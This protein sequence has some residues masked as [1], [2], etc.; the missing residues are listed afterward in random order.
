MRWTCF[1]FGYVLSRP[2]VVLNTFQFS[3]WLD[4]RNSPFLPHKHTQTHKNT[5]NSLVLTLQTP[6]KNLLCTCTY[7]KLDVK[8][9]WT[10]FTWL[11]CLIR[12]NS[13]FK[14]GSGTRSCVH[15]ET[16]FVYYCCFVLMRWRQKSRIWI[17]IDLSPNSNFHGKNHGSCGHAP[18]LHWLFVE[19]FRIHH[20]WCL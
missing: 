1:L 3:D 19:N 9:F 2:F 14:P 20:K 11:Y 16:I 5:F 12:R 13:T 15:G 4:C 6:Y 8:L 18:Y 17:T 10:S 7:M